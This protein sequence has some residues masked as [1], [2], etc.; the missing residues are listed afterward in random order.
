MIGYLALED[1][2]VYKGTSFGA[3]GGKEGEVIFNTSLCGYQ[4]IITDPSYKGQIV[5]GF[6]DED[7]E[8]LGVRHLFGL[9]YRISPGLLFEMQHELDKDFNRFSTNTYDTRFWLRHYFTLS[10]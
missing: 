9:E 6:N 7:K 5:S 1:G 2:T 4:E 10:D 8:L 3:F